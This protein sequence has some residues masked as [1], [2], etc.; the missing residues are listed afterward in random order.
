[1]VDVEADF[2]G[3]PFDG[4]DVEGFVEIFAAGEFCGSGEIGGGAVGE[5]AVDGAVDG[6]GLFADIFHDVDFAAFGPAD[7]FDVVAEHPEG[8]PDAL[9]LR[10]FDAGFEAAEGLGEEALGFQARGSVFAGDV[11]GAFEIFF[12][13]GDDEI[14]VFDVGVFAAI[15][16]GLELVVAPAFAAEVVGPF[17][18][19]G[20]GA[21]GAVEFVGPDEREIFRRRR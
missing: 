14:A 6:G 7:G 10:D 3:F 13:R 21:V 11:I 4:V 1:M 20:G 8:G 19:V 12:A 18:R 2:G 9:A 17:F 16:V 5:R 15:G